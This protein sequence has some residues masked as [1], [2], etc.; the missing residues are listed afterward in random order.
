MTRWALSGIAGVALLPVL[1]IAAA[2]GA[3]QG[4]GVADPSMTASADIPPGYLQLY[5]AAG[6]AYAIPWQ[7]LAGIGKVECDHG[8]NP[9]PACT[10]EGAV[11]AAGA[12]GP[13]QFLASTW[14]AYGVDADADGRADRW[15]PADAIYGAANY[16]RASGA[17]NDIPT[18]VYAYNHSQAYVDDVLAWADLYQQQAATDTAPATTGANP[19]SAAAQAASATAPTNGRMPPT[20]T[21]PCACSRRR[22]RYSAVRLGPWEVGSRGASRSSPAPPP[23]SAAGSRS[24][25]PRRE[26]RWSSRTSAK[27]RARAASRPTS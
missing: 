7:V 23:G 12:G 24:A 13:M 25:S 1:V 10:Q 15:D 18:A 20:S 8:R 17:P 3:F 14:A 26:R 2:T 22:S 27:I 16:L 21:W 4:I 11:N 5:L 9:D 19:S 6:S